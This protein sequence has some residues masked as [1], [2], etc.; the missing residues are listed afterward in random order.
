MKKILLYSLLLVSSTALMPMESD[1]FKSAPGTPLDLLSQLGTPSYSFS[2]SESEDMLPGAE[3]IQNSPYL[4]TN[5]T[6]LLMHRATRE[7]ATKDLSMA[8]D[9]TE[10]LDDRVEAYLDGNAEIDALT[11]INPLV[12]VNP[13]LDKLLVSNNPKKN[14]AIKAIVLNAPKGCYH[15]PAEKVEQALQWEDR[16]ETF[17]SAPQPMTVG[18]KIVS[19]LKNPF[20]KPSSVP[21]GMPKVEIARKIGMFGYLINQLELPN[22][23][24][25]E[26]F[27][28]VLSEKVSSVMQQL[29]APGGKRSLTDALEQLTMNDLQKVHS[30]MRKKYPLTEAALSRYAKAVKN[31]KSEWIEKLKLARATYDQ[32]QGIYDFDTQ[33]PKRAEFDEIVKPI[34]AGILPGYPID[35]I[36]GFDD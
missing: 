29:I 24:K 27:E 8:I 19:L 35:Q 28:F 1:D 21:N 12:H 25:D 4:Y 30:N 15:C 9:F 13:I 16:C 32:D 31:A 23:I 20:S 11:T 2:D 14:E 17:N 36:P 18:E 7:N 26:I 33:T 3:K 5:P 22:H 34:V 6:H 10:L